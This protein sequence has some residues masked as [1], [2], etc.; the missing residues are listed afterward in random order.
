MGHL[1]QRPGLARERGPRARRLQHPR[2]LRAAGLHDPDIRFA[3]YDNAYDEVQQSFSSLAGLS[4]G[5]LLDIIQAN[6]AVIEDAG[7]P[8]ASYIAPGTDHTILGYNGMYDL[9][10]EGVSFLDWLNDFVAGEDVPDVVCTDC[11]NPADA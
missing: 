4:D 11:E 10:V 9:E 3:R 6:E 2:A 5:D 8:V 1:Q 7:V